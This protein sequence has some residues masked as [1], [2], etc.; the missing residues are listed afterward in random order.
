M[1]RKI[2]QNGRQAGSPLPPATAM[3]ANSCAAA[4]ERCN[5]GYHLETQKLLYHRVR[6]TLWVAVVL[7]PLF[8][9]LD[10]VVARQHLELFV[11]YR[12]LFALFCLLLLCLLRLPVG[13]SS[14]MSSAAAPFPR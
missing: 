10:F 7:Y 4:S 6:A 12:V 2:Q 9:I 3:T 11:A 14:P 13:R 8:T 1:S 5:A